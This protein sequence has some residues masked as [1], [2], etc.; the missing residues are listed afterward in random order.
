[1]ESNESERTARG[2][3]GWTIS[4][5][6]ERFT[7]TAEPAGAESTKVTVTSTSKLSTTL[8]D[9]GKNKRNVR[10]ILDHLATPL[11]TTQATASP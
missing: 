11:K 1:M 6:G 2:E 5:W 8:I 3:F 4:S 9:W 10:K 7:V